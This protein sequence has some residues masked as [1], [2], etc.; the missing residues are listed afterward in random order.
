MTLTFVPSHHAQY[1]IIPIFSLVQ[2]DWIN[3]IIGQGNIPKISQGFVSMY[4]MQVNDFLIPADS[5]LWNE[6][7]ESQMEYELIH[8]IANGYMHS[9]YWIYVH[10]LQCMSVMEIWCNGNVSVTSQAY[11]ALS[12][13]CLNGNEYIWLKLAKHWSKLDCFVVLVGR[14]SLWT[15]GLTGAPRRDIYSRI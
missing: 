14:W 11:K 13:K 10:K 2:G 6:E 5:G 8:K 9:G 12:K 15:G 7:N 4:M 1:I 3:G